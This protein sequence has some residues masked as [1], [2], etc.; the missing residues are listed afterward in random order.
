MRASIP[1]VI[2]LAVYCI[3]FLFENRNKYLTL[4]LGCL[5]LIG[6]VT[7]LTEFYRGFYYTSKAGRINLVA[8]EI[9]TLNKSFVRM[10]IF[11][12]D[13]N[14]Q[15]TAKEYETDVFWQFFAKKHRPDGK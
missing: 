11:G 7:P 14:H 9:Y 15:Y 13:A 3:K 5:L 4:V 1:A 2:L 12:W 6:A 10:P 8:D